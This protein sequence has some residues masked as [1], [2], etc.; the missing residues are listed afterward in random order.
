MLLVVFAG[1]GRVRR[2]P[3]RTQPQRWHLQSG[4]FLCRIS[5][6]DVPLRVHALNVGDFKP[7]AAATQHQNTW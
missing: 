2:D 3:D 6:E 1:G 4:H 7:D 5:V